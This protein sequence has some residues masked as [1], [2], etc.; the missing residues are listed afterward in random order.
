M[1]DVI[2][3][4]FTIMVDE[5]ENMTQRLNAAEAV[6]GFESPPDAIAATKSFLKEVYSDRHIPSRDKIRAIELLRKAEDKKAATPG[7][8]NAMG[9]IA[10]LMDSLTA[11]SFERLDPSTYGPLAARLAAAKR[12]LG[13]GPA[14]SVDVTPPDAA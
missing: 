3:P 7:T 13:K 2:A 6:L 14:P 12:K 10:E 9:G 4:L 5:G 11:D 8:A 1:S